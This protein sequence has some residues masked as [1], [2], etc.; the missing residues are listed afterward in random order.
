MAMTTAAVSPARTTDNAIAI[1]N[2]VCPGRERRRKIM[3]GMVADAGLA[4]K[5]VAPN[6]PS[7]MTKANAAP[8]MAARLTI[9]RSISRHTRKGEAPSTLAASRVSAG[10]DRSVGTVDLT[11]NG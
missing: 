9:G 4:T 2:D 7:D 6:S 10:T 1:P 8:T 5:D 3:V 11:T